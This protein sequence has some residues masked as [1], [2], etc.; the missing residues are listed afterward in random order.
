MGEQQGELRLAKA[1]I[2]KRHKRDEYKKMKEKHEE[3]K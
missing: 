3:E 1:L 2:R